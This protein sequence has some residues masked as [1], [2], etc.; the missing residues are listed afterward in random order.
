MGDKDRWE[1]VTHAVATVC[2]GDVEHRCQ[3]PDHGRTDMSRRNSADET[4]R[5]SRESSPLAASVGK[6][7]NLLTIHHDGG[8]TPAQQGHAANIDAHP[9]SPRGKLTQIASGRHNQPT[10]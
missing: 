5:K 7:D 8:K 2:L 10:E 6:P 4:R 1:N 3:K 9:R